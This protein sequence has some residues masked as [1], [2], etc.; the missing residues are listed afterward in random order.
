MR[1][2]KDKPLSPDEEE[3]LRCCGAVGFTI[4][5]VAIIFELDKMEVT[6]QFSQ[7]QGTVYDLYME[8]RYQN[9]LEI[10][11]AVLQSA[12]NGSTPAQQQ[13]LEYYASVDSEL[14]DLD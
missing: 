11:Q 12:K 7:K 13:I 10:K 8:G 2:L 14:R 4:A 1:D 9:E 6:R 3:H 5:Q